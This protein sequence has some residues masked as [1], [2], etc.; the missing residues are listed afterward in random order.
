M[1][2]Q[3]LAKLLQLIV[4]KE[5]EKTLPGI[6]E[7]E[8]NKALKKADLISG[9]VN[10]DVRILNK[11]HELH[12]NIKNRPNKKPAG[13]SMLPEEEVDP[14]GDVGLILENIK[15]EMMGGGIDKTAPTDFTSFANTI[16]TTPDS[17]LKL[18]S[19]IEKA[20]AVHND[21]MTKDYSHLIKPKKHGPL[22]E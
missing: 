8:L 7:K 13:I 11:A 22:G 3:K 12:E 4:R 19:N 17:D 20:A 21:I 15:R 9:G 5:L 6:L 2:L 10:S 14:N 1:D 18:G 16:Q